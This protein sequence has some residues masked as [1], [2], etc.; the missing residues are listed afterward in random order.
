MN[1]DLKDSI[2]LLQSFG[3]KVRE[4]NYYCL[5][6]ISEEIPGFFDWY[7]TT[8]T[9]VRTLNGKHRNLGTAIHSEELTVLI[10]KE[11]DL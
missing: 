10:N 2:E 7:H 11:I 8:G 1:I 3:Y 5:R 4:I 6:V 9:V